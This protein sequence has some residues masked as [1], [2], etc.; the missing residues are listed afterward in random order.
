MRR[1]NDEQEKLTKCR[2]SVLAKE[3]SD[4]VSNSLGAGEDEA[5]VAAVLHDLLEVLDHSVP[6]LHVRHDLD[7][8]SDTVVGR[9]FHRTDVDLNVV[10]EE[11][12]GELTDFLRPGGGPHAG[13]TVGTDLTDDLADLGLETHVQHAIGL[14][15][16]QVG[17]TAKVGTSGLQ[18]VNQTTGSG[19]AD[20]NTAAQVT[21]LGTLGDTTVDTGVA[22]ARGLSELGDFGLNLNRQFTSGGEDQ[23]D[24]AVTGGE[25]GL[26]VD[27]HDGRETVTQS[28]SGTGLGDTDDVATRESHGPTLR[29]NRGGALK[30]LRL[31]FGQDI[32][33]EASLVE[34]LDRARD[35][36]SLDG[37]LA[38]LAEVI[39]LTLGAGGDIGVFLVERLLELGKGVKIY[40]W[41]G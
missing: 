18:H 34:G 31:D 7:D 40:A 6:L 29:L 22:N 19:N 1:I 8:L 38:L 36:A 4:F 24:R 2:P 20:L 21:D 30:A 11:V 41:Q 9:K 23:N 10:V 16:N 14:V 25:K 3:A 13:L 12:G 28:L 5:L 26:G 15:K 27:V 32:L 39:H 17:D 37:H 35:V 33:R